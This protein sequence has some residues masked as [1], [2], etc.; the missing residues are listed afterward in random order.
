MANQ[1]KK[2]KKFVATAATATLVASAIVPVASAASFSDTTGN[3]HE[4]AISTLADAGII[5]GYADGTFKPNK[6]LTRSD[7]VKLLGKYLVTEG[8]E[9]PA[10]YKTSMRFSDLKST[11]NDELLQYAAVV[12]DNGVFSGS[13]G[14]LL[15]GD[16]ITRENM[17]IVLVRLVNTLKDVSLEEF[18]A[19]QSFTKEVKDINTAK[20][21][22]RSAIDVLDF[23][24]I[25]TATNF[26]PKNTVTRGQ[27]ATFLNNVIK[28]DFSG[29][30]VTGTVKAVNNTTVEVKFA[31][32][33]TNLA[34]LNFSIEG[35]E[36]TNKAIKQSDNKTV[37]LTTAAQEGGKTYAVKLNG[38]EI[39]KF[40]GVTAVVPTSVKITTESLQA[41]VGTN[42]TLKAQVTV[43]EGQSKAGVPVTFNVVN[44]SVAK[45]V[46]GNTVNIG[47]SSLNAPIVVEVLTD[48]NGVATYTYTRYAQTSYQIASHD[49]VQAY[50]TGAPTLRSFSKVYWANIAPLTV[51]EVVAANTTAS[52]SL[53]NGA[54]KVYKVKI[55]LEHAEPVLLNGV[56]Q[57]DA[58]GNLRYKVNVGFQENVGVTPDKA[59]KTID[60]ID[61]NGVNL[62]YPGQYTTS[63]ADGNALNAWVKEVEI[64]VDRNGEAIFT[65]SGNDAAVTPFV[66][67]DQIV[68]PANAAGSTGR[69]ENTELNYVLPKLTFAKQHTLGLTNVAK[70]QQ[71]AA[72]FLEDNTGKI[73]SHNGSFAGTNQ[74]IADLTEFQKEDIANYLDNGVI[75]VINPL[76]TN[77]SSTVVSTLPGYKFTSAADKVEKLR[78]TGGRDYTAT[79]TD[80]AGTTAPTNTPVQLSVA[81]GSSLKV[82]GGSLYVVDNNAGV[83]FELTKDT[84]KAGTEVVTLAADSKGAVSYTLIGHKDTYA[85]PT[86]FIE[87]GDSGSHVNTGSTSSTHTVKP[88]LD[89][90]DL[91]TAGEIVYFSDAVIK[92]ATLTK[93]AYVHE[94]R[95]G[96]L[97]TYQSVDQN[98]KEYRPEVDKVSRFLTTFQVS[99]T[100]NAVKVTP[101]TQ[102]GFVIDKQLKPYAT[103]AE[104]ITD[105]VYN[106]LPYLN[107]NGS[108]YAQP[109]TLDRTIVKEY[110]FDKG[111]RVVGQDSTGNYGVG[112]YE[113]FTVL[114]DLDGVAQIFVETNDQ[115][116]GTTVTVTASASEASLPQ[117]KTASHTFGN[118]A[119]AAPYTGVI[120]SVASGQVTFNGKLPLNFA[121]DTAKYF[122]I[123]GTTLTKD[124]F[125]QIAGQKDVSVLVQYKLENNLPVFTILSVNGATPTPI[126]FTSTT[127]TVVND[128]NTLGLVGTTATTSNA[129]VATASITA[130]GVEIKSVGAGTAVITVADANPTTTDAKINV[131][132]SSTGAITYTTTKAGVIQ[133][134]TQTVGQ[135]VTTAL[136]TNA[137]GEFAI[138]IPQASLTGDLAG[139]TAIK[140]TVNGTDYTGTLTSGYFVFAVPTALTEAAVKAAILTKTN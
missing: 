113:T 67:V 54:K 106:V 8:Y 93:E 51:T 98:G 32:E 122:L 49:E 78:N 1:P 41:P 20:A 48:E 5:K 140:L 50:A 42:V 112:G 99:T 36:V 65:L 6:E 85:T 23:Y 83:I 103:D 60:V 114:T 45:D 100:F 97:F 59:I 71:Y 137:F 7:V 132:V 126:V 18:V 96:Q 134:G 17:A 79:L 111:T 69:F 70:G 10:D 130:A 92:D 90:N 35:L 108:V 43:A 107:T 125:N 84:S 37:V 46:N 76:L 28:A 22:A 136:N 62:G 9:V 16:R 129:A 66:F 128:V 15:A 74:A 116:I 104:T 56:H 29:A 2:Y 19:T 55:A 91:Q 40:V 30:A 127:Q 44:S 120:A 57:K 88:A 80:A 77:I 95:T 4:A 82:L 87:S 26:L 39:G 73:G 102:Y 89:K 3:T 123:G 94:G 13:N 139:A 63:T 64:E 133:V 115:Q 86:V 110:V 131:T 124:E 24:D 75:D 25:T 58:A 72:G 52:N 31:E 109:T 12:A 68:N 21:E 138:A 119:V 27:F 34:A 47:T 118:T 33:V 135:Y 14:K 101:I 11:S 81:Y 38:E 117:L 105:P 53:T 61:A 121:A